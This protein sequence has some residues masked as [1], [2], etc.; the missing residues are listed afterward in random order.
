VRVE[1]RIDRAGEKSGPQSREPAAKL[2]DQRH[3]AEQQGEVDQAKEQRVVPEDERQPVEVELATQRT[4]VVLD[5]VE[6]AEEVLGAPRPD[7]GEEDVIVRDERP[8]KDMAVRPSCLLDG[9]FNRRRG[10]LRS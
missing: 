5:S 4:E 10:S 2:D 3:G 6:D 8:A 9:A 7:R 1:K